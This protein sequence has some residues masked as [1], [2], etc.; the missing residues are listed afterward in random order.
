MYNT[1]KVLLQVFFF[2]ITS[3]LHLLYLFQI[4][5][6]SL[7]GSSSSGAEEKGAQKIS[8]AASREH[9]F[10]R[11]A[12]LWISTYFAPFSQLHCMVISLVIAFQS[13]AIQWLLAAFGV[14]NRFAAM[15][16]LTYAIHP[17]L[18]S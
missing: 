17:Y 2:A 7:G 13:R 10:G 4:E 5:K 18:A 12:A 14:H 9:S 3:N 1:V 11:R 16:D 8:E 6:V 15:L